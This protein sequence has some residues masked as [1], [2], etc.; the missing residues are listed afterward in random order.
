MSFKNSCKG[1]IKI[2]LD[3]RLQKRR[4]V[5]LKCDSNFTRYYSTVRKVY[6]STGKFLPPLYFLGESNDH[7]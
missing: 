6:E 3:S 1:H 5:E 2:F 4:S 7:G